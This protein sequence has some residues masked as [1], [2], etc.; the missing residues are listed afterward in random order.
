MAETTNNDLALQAH[1]AARAC[2]DLADRLEVVTGH[3]I[4]RLRHAATESEDRIVTALASGDT[5]NAGRFIEPALAQC[6]AALAT[7]LADIE[8]LPAGL[9]G[10]RTHARKIVEEVSRG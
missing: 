1:A 5:G 9:G 2:S 3:V 10:V 6:A 7:A 8:Q 4:R